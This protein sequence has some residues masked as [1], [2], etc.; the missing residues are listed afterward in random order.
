M[1][2]YNLID[3]TGDGHGHHI[4]GTPNVFKHGWKP[5]NEATAAKAAAEQAEFKKA[6]GMTPKA[7]GGKSAGSLTVSH[8]QVTSTEHSVE[9]VSLVNKKGEVVKE[10]HVVRHL[11]K[12]ASEVRLQLYKE[13]GLDTK[14]PQT[15]IELHDMWQSTEDPAQKKE[16]LLELK[17]RQARL[18]LE[19]AALEQSATDTLR[20]HKRD[21]WRQWDSKLAKTPGGRAVQRMRDK[22]LS[23]N[24]LDKFDKVKEHIQ[25][26][27]LEY[28]KH[29]ATALAIVSVLHPVGLALGGAL[30]SE[31][32]R[33][34]AEKLLE[35]LWVHAGLS[36]A[37]AP[38]LEKFGINPIQRRFDRSK[39]TE[40]ALRLIDKSAGIPFDRKAVK[41]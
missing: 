21:F 31:H 16:I 1:T 15:D 35:S 23:D 38:L 22:I 5:L 3:L 24:V 26:R 40:K 8:R 18:D 20:E 39:K 30:A 2:R 14:F 33:E 25:E 19:V 11:R 7:R 17:R 36:V 27:G 34:A 9:K 6:H 41:K 37:L 13:A 12:Q 32:G 10:A 4:P 28:A 29:V